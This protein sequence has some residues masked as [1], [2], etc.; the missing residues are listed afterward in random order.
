[1]ANFNTHITYAAAASGLLSVL[2]LQIGL[3]SQN[4]ALMLALTGTIGGILPDIDLKRSYPSQLLF[5]ML[6]IIAAFSVVFRYEDKLSIIELW[7]V[8]SGTLWFVR[9]PLWSLFHLNTTHRGSIH[10]IVAGLFVSFSTVAVMSHFFN[11]NNILA[12]FFGLFMFF[13]FIIHLLLDELY[14]VDFSNRRIK[15]SF[16]TAMKILDARKPAKSIMLVASTTIA[17]LLTPDATAFWDTLTSDETYTIISHRI[18]PEYVT[19][20]LSQL[21]P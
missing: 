15:R 6:G 12:W 21:Y 13:G 9:Y 20:G 1:M 19:Q 17:W 7:I 2:C 8:G 18:F 14:S 16:G 10:S 3:V 11:T 4:E 5:G